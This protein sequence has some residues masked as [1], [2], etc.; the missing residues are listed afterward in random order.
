MK[1][2]QTQLKDMPSS[3]LAELGC[4]RYN[5]FTRGDGWSIPLR[6]RASGQEYDSFDCSN[7]TWLIAWHQHHGICGCARL[8]QWREANSP[9]S[10]WA[11]VGLENVWEMSRFSA[12]LEVDNQLP[13]NILW[14]AV[15]L[16]QLS[17]IAYLVSAA[18]PMQ[19]E[20]F[21]H[22]QVRF[23]PLTTDLILDKKPVSRVKIPLSQPRLAEKYSGTRCFSPEEVLPSLGVSV[24]WQS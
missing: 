2:I 6:L 13:L 17:G 7:V 12:C 14:H 1:I 8:M 5:V 4:Y 21:K 11:P 23:E 24:N 16:A 10:S 3:L 22:Y 20:M 9:A 18:T 19:E 15:Q